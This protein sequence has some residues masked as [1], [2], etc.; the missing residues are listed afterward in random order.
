MFSRTIAWLRIS[1]YSLFLKDLKKTNEL[2]GM[3]LKDSTRVA[4]R[5]YRSLRP[6]QLRALK[7]RASKYSYPALDAFNRLQRE[8]A[9]RLTHLKNAQRQRVIGDMWRTIQEQQKADALKKVNPVKKTMKLSRSLKASVKKTASGNKRSRR[10][11]NARPSAR[12]EPKKPNKSKAVRVED[13]A[14]LSFAFLPKKGVRPLPV[15]RNQ[16][17]S[18]TRSSRSAKRKAVVS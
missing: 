10:V 5:M 16:P 2:A 17:K 9:Y 14:Q 15:I 11:A 1:P 3:T 18:H 8:N 13:A 12:A 7:M 4:S 6:A